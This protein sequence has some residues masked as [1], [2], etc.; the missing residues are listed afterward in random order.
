M[1]P[2]I[3]KPIDGYPDYEISSCGRVR[4]QK[5][6]RGRQG[7]I[8]S[9]SDRGQG[10]RVVDLIGEKRKRFYVHRLV[11]QHFVPNPMNKPCVNHIDCNPSNNSAE[12]LEWCTNKEN[13]EWMKKLGRNQRTELWRSRLR[14]SIVEKMGKPIIATDIE[15]G[16]ESFFCTVN[17]TKRNGYQPSCVTVC[18]QGKRK[19]HKGKKWRYATPEEISLMIQQM[20]RKE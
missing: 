5:E 11:A 8:T 10:Y 2:E 13:S 12:N 4:S 7:Y 15:T 16:E 18:C 20:E 3:W 9:G 17:E 19:Y 14:D 1:A 6:W